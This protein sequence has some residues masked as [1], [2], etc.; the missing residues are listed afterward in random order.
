MEKEF[1]ASMQ[2][3]IRI[4]KWKG[5]DKFAT[6][7]YDEVNE[8]EY[9]ARVVGRTRMVRNIRG[10]EVVSTSTIYVFGAPGISPKDRI[11]KADGTRPIILSVASFPDDD[12]DHH[13]IV[14]T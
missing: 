7:I 12:G 10:Q 14:Y 8:T 3:I 9:N 2:N 6:A 4:A 13:E 1:L 5:V 11:T